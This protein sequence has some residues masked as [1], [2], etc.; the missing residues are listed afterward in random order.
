MGCS[1]WLAHIA[2]LN[3]PRPPAQGGTTHSVLG[4]PFHIKSYRQSDGGI[5]N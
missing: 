1:L 5:S 2:F 4:R 3:N